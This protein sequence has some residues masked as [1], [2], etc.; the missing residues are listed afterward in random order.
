M[1]SSRI[2]FTA[3]RGPVARGTDTQRSAV[4]HPAG[5]S[6]TAEEWLTLAQ[7]AREQG[8][9][10]I[11]IHYHSTIEIRG[12][13][14]DDALTAALDDLTSFDVPHAVTASPL[15]QSA[16][17]T[18][19]ELTSLL[20]DSANSPNESIG[21]DDGSGDVLASKPHLAFQLTADDRL[22][23]AVNGEL[24]GDTFDRD[25]L[26]QA[27]RQLI[28]TG[29]ACGTGPDI[30]Q[31]TDDERAQHVPIGWLAEHTEPGT[32]D[33]GAGIYRGILPADIAELFGKAELTTTITPWRGVVFHGLAEGD[34]EAVLRV[35]APKGLLFDI[36]SPH[37]LA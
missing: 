34:A 27:I 25:E 1:D 7:A 22:A 11:Y 15:S 33:L 9:G 28:E 31:L 10:Y 36:N 17:D 26:P 19:V 13:Y 32:V 18:A 8:D 12:I 5:G 24:T 4:L 21:I 2:Q 35:L 29:D 14:D 37:L 16:R 6:V 3:S 23:S 20:A 30:G